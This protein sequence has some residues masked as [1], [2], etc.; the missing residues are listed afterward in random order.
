MLSCYFSRI[1]IIVAKDRY[2]GKYKC[3]FGRFF[4]LDMLADTLNAFAK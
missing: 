1:T 4:I 2:E 3:D